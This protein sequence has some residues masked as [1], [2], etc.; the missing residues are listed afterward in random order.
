M[1]ERILFVD[2]EKFVLDTFQRNLRGKFDIDT[3]E[4][5]KSALKKLEAAEFAVVVA[6]MRMPN[7]SGAELLEVVKNRWP[8]TVRIMLTGYADIDNAMKAVNRGAVFRFLLKPC[9]PD[10]LTRALTDALE[11]HR[12][13]VAEKQLL[14]GTLR[15]CVQIMS[16]LLEL[17]NPT[18]YGRGER[19]KALIVAM[20]KFLGAEALW[21]YELAAMLSQIGC[22]SLPQDIL[23]RR[24]A[25][26]TLS[27]EEEQI[28][29]MH[30]AIAANV[31][32]NLPRLEEIS[33]MVA[34]QEAPL[35][36]NPCLG[37]RI[38]KVALD[39]T[40]AANR[41]HEE[42]IVEHMRQHPEIYDPRIVGAL[43]W[44]LVAQAGQ[45]V[46]RL[47]I[48]ELRAGMVLAEPV[49][50]AQG[51]TLMRK[52]QTISQAAIERFQFAQV[53]GIREPIAVLRPKEDASPRCPMP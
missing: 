53:L 43:Q 20:A 42:H 7:M 50:T 48:A 23:E 27:P 35:E 15:G 28:F 13:L 49:V 39:Y 47:P 9:P 25:G 44:Y 31:L 37:A 26:E 38:L 11:Q 3:A 52:G 2:D 18:A 16:E 34:D 36:K 40:D 14:H 30:P 29:L 4:G 33:E 45:Q 5:P 6:D 41:G 24:L 8:Q 17:A 10:A 22:L 32:R 21:K 46:E 51:Q 19:A 12:L 1:P